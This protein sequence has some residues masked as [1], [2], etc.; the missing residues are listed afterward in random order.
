MQQQLINHPLGHA[1]TSAAAIPR[2]S[3]VSPKRRN[4]GNHLTRASART[5]VKPA[6][7]AFPESRTWP[8][9]WSRFTTGEPPS[10]AAAMKAEFSWNAELRPDL[11]SWRYGKIKITAEGLGGYGLNHGQLEH[12]FPYATECKDSP[13]A[14]RGVAVTKLEVTPQLDYHQFDLPRNFDQSFHIGFNGMNLCGEENL[15]SSYLLVLGICPP[16]SAFLGPKC[17]LWDCARPAQGGLD[18]WQV[19]CSRFHH[20]LALDKGLPGIGPV[21]RPGGIGLKDGLLFAALRAKAEGSDVGVLEGAATTK[22]PWNAPDLFDL[23]VLDGETIREWLF[24][25]KPRRAFESGNSK[26]RSIPDYSGRGWHESRKRFMNEFGGLKRSYYMDPQPLNNF[27]WHLYEYEIN[28]RDVCALYRLEL[29]GPVL[30]P[31]GIGLKDGLLFAAVGAKAE[32]KFNGVPEWRELQPQSLLGM[33]LS[34][35]CC[36]Q[37]ASLTTGLACI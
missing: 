29:M 11:V 8:F 33:L 13:S 23:S 10:A 24:F 7:I 3:P 18:F 19:Y 30:R 15:A 36:P 2:L 32:E 20:D 1:A 16:P 37:R 34:L 6:W 22:S 26:Q 12:C 14:G 4:I 27:E 31:G 5:N 21:L 35:C 28:N 17:A 9:T 25:D